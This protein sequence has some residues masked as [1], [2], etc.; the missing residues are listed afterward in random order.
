MTSSALPSIAA[1]LLV[2]GCAAPA[3]S[4]GAERVATAFEAP[5][6]EDLDLHG[7]YWLPMSLG[8]S[9]ASGTILFPLKASGLDIRIQLRVGSRAAG[10]EAPASGAM[11]MAKLVDASNKTVAE[12]MI[13]PPE[14]Q[15]TIETA[16]ATAGECQLVLDTHGGSD[17]R[18]NGDYVAYE[19]TAKPRQA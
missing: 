2:A 7:V 11:V 16:N 10:L 18:A 8:P 13:M 3:P 4:F 5:V 15:A 9:T 6:V 1:F 14:M 12:A 17:G 19:I